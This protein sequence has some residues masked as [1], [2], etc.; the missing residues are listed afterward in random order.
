VERPPRVGIE[1][2]SARPT[3]I[4]I[5]Q[6]GIRRPTRPPGIRRERR[7]PTLIG[8]EATGAPRRRPPRHR[9]CLERS[10]PRT[11]RPLERAGL[12]GVGPL[13][14]VRTLEQPGRLT[15]AV[16]LAAVGAA[17]TVGATGTP[18]SRRCGRHRRGRHLISGPV[19]LCTRRPRRRREQ[20]SRW[21]NPSERRRARLPGRQPTGVH[22]GTGRTLTSHP[23]TTRNRR[24]RAS[25]PWISRTRHTRARH[26]RTAHAGTA[27]AGTS[28]NR[29]RRTSH[30]RSTW[31][32][33]ARPP[34]AR[35]TRTLRSDP[36]AS[37][38][39]TGQTRPTRTP[40]SHPRTGGA[41]RGHAG[42]RHL[43]T[44]HVRAAHARSDRRTNPG[45]RHR[46]D[47]WSQPGRAG[48]IG[49][50]RLVGE[51]GRRLD[52]LAGQ[53]DARAGW[54]PSR[55]DTSAAGGDRCCR[56]DT[57]RRWLGCL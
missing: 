33:R 28:R 56:R 13:P 51:R 50:D 18:G 52:D 26:S 24:P 11:L 39:V 10:W 34:H 48:G 42:P 27:H 5:E 55:R 6:P 12:S 1:R 14:E 15:A 17:V 57:A 45:R 40:S 23:R 2:P 32:T 22:P 8:R 36:R 30:P 31:A 4:R 49:G 47:G 41:L 35:A 25:H 20:V 37:R 21:P 44:A 43:G 29:R 53:H 3:R 16:R 38:T 19:R 9:R 7:R 54:A 46:R